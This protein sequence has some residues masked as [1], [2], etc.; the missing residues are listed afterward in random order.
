[1]DIRLLVETP[2][3]GLASFLSFVS[4]AAATYWG[5]ELAG[6]IGGVVGWLL[7]HVFVLGV[8]FPGLGSLIAR[9]EGDAPS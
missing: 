5:I 6:A 1:M 4:P 9:M 7:S 2:V 3:V 8:I